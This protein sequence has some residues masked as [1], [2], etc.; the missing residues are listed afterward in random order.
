MS[1]IF[2]DLQYRSFISYRK[3]KDWICQYHKL[4]ILSFVIVPFNFLVRFQINGVDVHSRDQAIK[5]FSEKGSDIKLLLARPQQVC[6]NRPIA[7]EYFT[8]VYLN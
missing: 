1:K 5:L 8:C 6:L 4:S 7:V 2:V 3:L